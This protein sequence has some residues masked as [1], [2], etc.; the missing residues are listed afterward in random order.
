MGQRS[1]AIKEFK[2]VLKEAG[3]PSSVQ[4]KAAAV[5]RHMVDESAKNF[6][7]NVMQ[8]ISYEMNPVRIFQNAYQQ[9]IGEEIV[10]GFKGMAPIEVPN[11]AILYS[12]VPQLPGH[13]WLDTHLINGNHALILAVYNVYQKTMLNW[14]LSPGQTYAE[15]VFKKELMELSTK[16]SL[17]LNYESLSNPSKFHQVIAQKFPGWAER[18]SFKGTQI[19]VKQMLLS[20]P[21]VLNFKLFG[22]Y[23]SLSKFFTENGFPSWQQIVVE[24]NDFIINEG[25]TIGLQTYFYKVTQTQRIG[26]WLIN[27]NDEFVNGVLIKNKKTGAM[28][29]VKTSDLARAF[30]NFVKIPILVMDAAVLF[31]ASNGYLPIEFLSFGD[32]TATV[33]QLGLVGLTAMGRVWYSDAYLERKFSRYVAKKRL[34]TARKENPGFLKDRKTSMRKKLSKMLSR[35]TR[36]MAKTTQRVS[37]NTWDWF[38]SLTGLGQRDK[39]KKV[40][41]IFSKGFAYNNMTNEEIMSKGILEGNITIDELIYVRKLERFYDDGLLTISEFNNHLKNAEAGFLDQTIF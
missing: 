15:K 26:K 37:Q 21:F 12:T 24:A 27:Q 10:A 5:P 9:P 39:E 17:N 6:F 29:K 31:F 18:F 14:L 19:F 2:L 4:V 28:E 13:T 36:A 22:N 32:F 16:M 30:V 35:E 40:T 11:A 38:K 41:T 23:S 8:D 7:V 20:M 33:P 25:L 1:K 3:A 34:K